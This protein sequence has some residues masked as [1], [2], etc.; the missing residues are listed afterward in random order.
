[1]QEHGCDIGERA[2]ALRA[3]N[4]AR[5][6]SILHEERPIILPNY[7]PLDVENETIHHDQDDRHDREK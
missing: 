1:M 7:K 6:D 3:R 5:R 4:Q 2:R